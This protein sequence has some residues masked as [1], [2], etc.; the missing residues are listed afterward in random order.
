[1]SC[2]ALRFL[3]WFVCILC[4]QP[5]NRFTFLFPF[6]IADISVAGAVGCHLMGCAETGRPFIKF[7]RCSVLALTLMAC[8]LI[9]QNTGPLM[10]YTGWN[11]YIDT[12][13]KSVLILV[14]AEALCSSVPRV[15]MVQA[16]LLLATLWWIKAGLRLSSAGATA[17]GDRL[18]GPAV[19]LVE[20]PNGFAYM[21]CVMIP[22]YLYFYQQVTNR[23]ARWLYLAIAISAVYIVLRTGSR[24]GL[25]CLMA[26]GVFLL[27][28]YF[29]RHKLGLI[30]GGAAIF[31]LFPNIGA[32]NI[33]RFKTIP[34]SF[35][36]FIHGV[37]KPEDAMDQDEQSAQERK[38]KNR[39]TWRLILRYPVFGV[40][41][42][43]GDYN[44]PRDLPNARGQVHCEVLMAGKQMGFVGIGLYLGLVY[45][46]FSY[47]RRIERYCKGWWPSVSD[48]GWTFKM[49]ALVFAIGGYFSPLPFN[50]PMM[51]LCGSVSALWALVR[52]V[53]APNAQ[54]V[55]ATS[56]QLIPA[57]A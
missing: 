17:S 41:M 8:A 37:D 4:T 34:Q 23:Y 5:Q 46:L 7:G 11:P 2:W 54:G 21:M 39:D 20:N 15:W 57:T 33:Q 16:A 38:M 22:L 53:P 31:L 42:N 29:A 10:T 56:P 27:P 12:V 9:S 55:Y 26:L 45:T 24:T 48:L 51:L 40:G 25:L 32:L 14:L 52:A 47:G 6:H 30:V 13:T 1:M 36:N 49:Q 44:I 19:S 50:M 43:P 35:L 18:M 3:L 28:K